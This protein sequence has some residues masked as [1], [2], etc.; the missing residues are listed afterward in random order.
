MADIDRQVGRIFA[1]GGERFNRGGARN[2][3][4]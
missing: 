4:E 2:S 3:S 1:N